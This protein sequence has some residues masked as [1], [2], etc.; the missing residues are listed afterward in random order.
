M[1]PLQLRFDGRPTGVRGPFD[2]LSNVIKGHS[3][4]TATLACL[5]F[6]SLSRSA[7][8][9][10]RSAVELQS[11][12]SCDDHR[13]RIRILRILKV[14]KIHEFVRILKMSVLKFVKFKL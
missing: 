12:R 9:N 11:N 10:G 13:L 5:V 14:R 2:C 4:V 3:D 8:S 7:S 1:P 6:I